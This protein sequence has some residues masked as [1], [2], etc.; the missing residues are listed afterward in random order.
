[1]E[2]VLREMFSA[3]ASARDEGRRIPGVSTPSL[4]ALT[5]RARNCVCKDCR[6]LLSMRSKGAMER[7]VAPAETRFNRVVVPRL[8][9]RAPTAP[10]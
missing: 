8:Y 7:V 3:S 9:D 5:I 4:I 6:A 1:M 10:P 2:T